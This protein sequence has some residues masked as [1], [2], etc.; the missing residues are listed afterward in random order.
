MEIFSLG[1]VIF[2]LVVLIVELVVY[3]VRNMRSI[4]RAKIRKRLRHFTYAETGLEGSNI[5]KKRMYSDVGWLNTLLTSLPLVQQVD[6][7]VIQ[8]NAKYPIGFYI[9]LSLLLA[10]SG[11][12]AAFYFTRNWAYAVLA[13]FIG[14]MVPYA[15]LTRKKTQRIEKFKKQLPDALDLIARALKAGHAFSGSLSMV[16][17]EFDDPIG[18]EF[19]ESLDEINYG[20]SVS[21]ALKN[22]AGRIGCDELKYFIVGVILQRETGGNLAELMETLA[23]LIRE[24]F[25]FEGKVRTLTAEG[26][27]S[28][29]VLILLPILLT[30]YLYITNPSFLEPLFKESSGRLMAVLAV[31]GMF[32]GAIVMRRMVN[33]KV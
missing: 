3:S 30:I 26:K 29:V 24:R 8:A 5:L 2:I 16:S 12:Y 31:V 14:L 19:S 10:F 4:Q 9:L 7:L 32:V 1:A 6:R 21:D 27:F 28:A 15:S 17:E 18:P 22:L 33:L 11:Y 20:V 23:N 13:S 25:K